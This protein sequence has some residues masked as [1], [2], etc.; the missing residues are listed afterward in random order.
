[1]AQNK[2]TVIDLLNSKFGPGSTVS[3]QISN[4]IMEAEN[5][6]MAVVRRE[7]G[8]SQNPNLAGR[9]PRPTATYRKVGSAVPSR[10][11]R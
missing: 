5:Q 11:K 6:Q 8:V 10:F 2:K 4:M 1:M 9:T 3:P 7:R